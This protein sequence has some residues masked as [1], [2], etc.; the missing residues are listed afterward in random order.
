MPKPKKSPSYNSSSDE[1]SGYDRSGS[2]SD[3][4]ASSS[5]SSSSRSPSPK[6]KPVK[7]TTKKSG[8]P[9]SGW[10]AFCS[11]KRAGIRKKHPNWPMTD[12]TKEL[13]SMWRDL[14]DRQKDKYNK[15]AGK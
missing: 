5:H 8:K 2:D 9:R 14:S 12:V 11:E 6:R 1:S 10:Q 3:R 7:K 13:A 4:Y 15:K